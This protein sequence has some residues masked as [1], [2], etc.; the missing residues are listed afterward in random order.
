MSLEDPS[1]KMSKSD[2]NPNSAIAL[3]DDADTIR[4]KI[5]RAVTDSGSE[6]IAAPD[7]PALTN[8]LTIFSLLSEEPVPDL[9]ARYAGKGYGAF[10]TDLAD[11][12]VASVAPIQS[13]L[14]ELND[15]PEVARR[16]LI[17]GAERARARAAAKMI[18][19]R[20]RMGIGI[21]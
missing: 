8:L 4:R 20:D 21:G 1:R 14:A 6:V 12:V 18:E 13:R 3:S 15:D 9:E 17:D 16:V 2:A 5:R 11:V 10:K 7:K 19:V